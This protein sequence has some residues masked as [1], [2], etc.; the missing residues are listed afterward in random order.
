MEN[1]GRILQGLTPTARRILFGSA[2][3]ASIDAEL[4]HITSVD[5]AHMV[6]LAE[7]G[8]V[9][10]TR[11][12]SLL[13]AIE[14]L[15]DSNF[16]PLRGKPASRGLYLL[17]ENYL[18]EKLGAQTGGILQTARSRNDL[19]ATVLLLRLRKPYMKLL[20]EAL[21]L[22]C[23]LL[24]RA[25]Q[26]ADV[27]MPIYT[28][29]QPA[30]PITYGHYLMGI[31]LSMESGI[32]GLLNASAILSRSPL[33][34]GS[35]G[36]TTLP[37]DQER[38][39]ALL[40]FD[41]SMP[42]SVEAVASR[43]II[44]WL[45]ASAT[46]LGVTLSRVATDLLLWTMSEVGF[47][48]LSDNLVGSSSMMPQKRNP[49]I[50]EHIQGRSS[51]P[52]GGFVAAVT[53]MHSTPFSNSIAVGTEAVGHVWKALQHITEAA[54]LARLVIDGGKPQRQAM[55][56]RAEQGY[57]SATELANR[58]A[59]QAGMSFRTAHHTVGTIVRESIERQT[60]LAQAAA[61][62][63]S[64]EQNGMSLDGLDP[65]SVAQA[66]VYGGGPGEESLTKCLNTTKDRW[67][68]NMRSKRELR[69]KWSAAD[70]ALDNAVKQ[71]LDCEAIKA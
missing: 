45:L 7:C 31:A 54:T 26:Y 59:M 52:L 62:R 67:R 69:E 56:E 40:G 19:N 36:G 16:E 21:R 57:T 58:L 14:T 64:Q 1:T 51:S 50:L 30:M 42:N 49:F 53:A 25:R 5:K 48:T 18:I 28:H 6:M 23:V 41:S 47:I 35:V 38:T 60:P 32:S 71:L 61:L 44:T 46:I 68:A 33:G 66:S 20:S 34:A 63:L 17:Y 12:C 24:R 27:V 37:I 70:F 55:L 29:F 9:D 8:I 13:D 10:M 3:D 4:A 43:D 22:Q 11:A 39:A 65:S 2:A 15:Q